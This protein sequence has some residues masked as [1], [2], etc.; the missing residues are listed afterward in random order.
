MFYMWGMK[1]DKNTKKRI[2]ALNKIVLV[3]KGGEMERQLG[4]EHKTLQK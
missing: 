1:G 4:H 3:D 2:S